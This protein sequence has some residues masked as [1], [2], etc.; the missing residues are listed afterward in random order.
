M[1]SWRGEPQVLAERVMQRARNLFNSGPLDDFSFG[2]A[3]GELI[4]ICTNG[5]LHDGQFDRFADELRSMSRLYAKH[6]QAVE[7]GEAV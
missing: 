7:A 3:Y 5:G 4:V 2:M 6:A 1:N